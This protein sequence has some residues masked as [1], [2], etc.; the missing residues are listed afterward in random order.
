MWQPWKNASAVALNSDTIYVFGGAQSYH[1]LDSIEKYIIS[2]N[3]WIEVPITLPNPSSFITP[4]KI[5][6]K[7]ILLFGGMVKEVSAVGKKYESDKIFIFDVM[8]PDI[9]LSP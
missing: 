8:G 4:F 2:Q 6:N 9:F 1:T 3:V 7:Q 5:S